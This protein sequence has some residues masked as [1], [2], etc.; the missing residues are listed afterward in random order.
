MQNRPPAIVPEVGD[1]GEYNYIDEMFLQRQS[2]VV[3]PRT[4]GIQNGGTE[5]ENSQ[6]ND[7]LELIGTNSVYESLSGIRG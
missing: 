5:A 7:Y 3:R 4:P 6:R 2:S 1:P